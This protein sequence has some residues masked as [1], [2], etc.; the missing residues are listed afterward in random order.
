MVITHNAGF[1]KNKWGAGEKS[2]REEG[3][4]RLHQTKNEDSSGETKKIYTGEFERLVRLEDFELW[5]EELRVPAPL[6]RRL[7][8]VED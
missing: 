7:K 2:G 8:W 3:P 5:T 4:I 6:A 1:P